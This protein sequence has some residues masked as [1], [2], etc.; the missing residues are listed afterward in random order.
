LSYRNDFGS[1]YANKNVLIESSLV[2]FP[3]EGKCPLLPMPEGAHPVEKN[4][5]L[6]TKSK[7]KTHLNNT[8]SMHELHGDKICIFESSCNW[9]N[10]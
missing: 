3:G 9:N 1:F 2:H 10:L 7:R 4:H 5:S 8:I 6:P